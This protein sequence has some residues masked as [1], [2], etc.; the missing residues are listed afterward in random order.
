[1]MDMLDPF[2]LIHGEMLGFGSR[3]KHGCLIALS[4]T[5]T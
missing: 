1:M 3:C 4:K 5:D 2:F